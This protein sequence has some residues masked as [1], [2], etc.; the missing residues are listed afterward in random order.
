MNHYG[1]TE[2]TVG[3]ITYP[4]EKGKRVAGTPILPL[5]RPLPNSRIY[6]LDRH[7]APMPIGVPG[8]VFIGGAGVAR[9]YLRQP[10]LTQERFLPDP[11]R[12]G[13]RVYRTGDRARILADEIEAALLAHSAVREA[14]VLVHE[15][16]PG[17]Q[18]LVGYV[19]STP[20]LDAGAAFDVA[21]LR[22]ALAQRLPEYMIPPAFVVLA[23]MPLTPNGKVD[24]RALATLE[25]Q[26]QESEAHSYV[27]PRNPIEEVIA[28]IW[29][30]IFDK[31]RVGVHEKF[32]D[33]GGHSLLAIQIIARAREAF[34]V[35]VALRAIFESPTI[36]GLAE[37]V[38][39]AMHEGEGTPPPPIERVSRDGELLLSFAQERLWFLHQLEPQS[40]YYNVPSALRLSGKLDLE[41]LER[42][43][44]EIVRRHEV[45]RT[46]FRAVSGKPLQIVHPEVEL[47]LGVVR[48]PELRPEE[49]EEAA[50]KEAAEEARRPFDLATGPVFRAGLLVLGEDDHVLLLTLHHIVSDG[51]TRGILNREL[52]TLY[53]AYQ[54][55][56]DA[57]LPEVPIQYA[58][59]AQWQRRWLSGE[60]LDRQ[61]AYWKTQLNG[62]P[63]A[64]D[65]PT[66][67]PRPRVQTYRGGQRLK[68]L[69]REIGV[70]LKEL[71]RR[72]GVTLYMILLSAL[73]VLLHR[74]TGQRDVVVGTSVSNRNR[75]ETERLI[76]FFINALVLRTEVID[77][78][79]FTELLQRVREVC[80][81]AY[82]HQDMPFER[83]V[84]E[85]Q[86]EPDP[87][88][89]PL[90][91]VI[92]TMQNAPGEAMEMPGL[93]LRGMRT[94]SATVKY[95][96]TF[97]MGEGKDGA[98]GVSIEYNVDLFDGTTIDRMVGHLS[99]L[100]EGI[101]KDASRRVA[102]L[103]MIP[104][105]E[106]QEVLV[107]WN[108]TAA[109]Y[110]TDDCVHELFEAQAEVTPDAI[111]VTSGA[112]HLTFR[113]LDARANRLA[114]YLRS[115]GVGPESVVGLCLGR[116]VE[117]I[118][119]LLGILKAGG[120]YLPLDPTY[121]APRLAQLAL[122]AGA[123]VI[124][125][126]HRL[127]PR[128][129]QAP[130]W[131]ASTATRRPSPPSATPAWWA[132]SP[133]ATS[134]TCSSP[135]ARRESPRAWPSS[136]G[137]SSTT[138]AEW[139]PD[140]SC[141]PARATR[142]SPPSLPISA[143]PCSSRRYAWA[144]R[145]T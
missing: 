17:D 66:D 124:V 28:S 30:D 18:H 8:E 44:R 88:R 98:L 29:C 87:S 136:T 72:E 99:A 38:E 6:V 78:Q 82:A 3:V 64:I 110:S 12:P 143:T 26:K 43:L 22:V 133:R 106:R 100:L 113:Q 115:Q 85:L 47:R 35:D 10:E 56:E 67:R 129:P 126:E 19:V 122:D 83:L 127:P 48:W 89:A 51:W 31:E 119:A 134:L 103:A 105:D 91:Q 125:S 32:A 97:L 120:A 50:R 52:S 9:G 58:D 39:T 81:G 36:A 49:R 92:F 118:V 77:A 59:Y 132:R 42:A 73:D 139:R 121:P 108:D 4:V 109:S 75:A 128:S 114:H 79:P 62:A 96:L 141:R 33:L 14:V 23:A 80:L 61:I 57:A 7:R 60:V 95:D 116:S 137:T 53:R 1:P 27:A 41:A 76:G 144:A 145:S 102:D 93:Q 63:Q 5:G 16:T 140:S 135:R 68:I 13:E 40:P 130:P 138:F 84:Q 142:T 111:A 55:G 107:T 20:D 45:L 70:A 15:D 2:T 94:E 69:P 21:A 46:T 65:L 101:A 74:W 131:S 123:R 34:Q 54:V 104:D 90:F 112:A 86:P 11:F 117:V 71:A 37:Q 24:R 25:Q